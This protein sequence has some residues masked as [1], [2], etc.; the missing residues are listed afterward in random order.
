MTIFT[1][2]SDLYNRIPLKW[3]EVFRFGIVGGLATLVHYG[4]YLLLQLWIWT[5]L[6]YTLG[7]ALSFV[8]NYMLTN[9]FTFKTKPTVQN[10]V[11]FIISHAVNYG[12]H[13]GLLELFLWLDISKAW[14]PIPVYCLVIPI[15]FLLVR[16]VFKKI[17]KI[18]HNEQST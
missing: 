15:N 13:L 5:W 16:F 3:M 17:K 7:Y 6:A 2:I 18:N 11:G 9:Y 1:K 14:A 8:M 12:L 4:V 10:G